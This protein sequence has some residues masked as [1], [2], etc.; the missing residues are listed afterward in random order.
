MKEI[1]GKEMDI[2]LELKIGSVKVKDPMREKLDLEDKWARRMREIQL[3][4]K[5]EKKMIK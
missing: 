4:I 3:Q 5:K 1:S 2:S